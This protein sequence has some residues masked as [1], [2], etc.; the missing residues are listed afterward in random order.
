MLKRIIAQARKEL[1]QVSRPAHGGARPRAAADTA[2][3]VLLYF[4]GALCVLAGIGLGTFLATFSKVAT[5]GSVVEFFVNPPLGMLSG[6]MTPIDAMPDW[7]QPLTL[8]N[9]VRYFATTARGIM[10]KGAGGEVLYPNLLALIGFAVLL[11]GVSAW[12]FRK[13]LG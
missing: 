3:A 2:C 9:P 1:T 13:Q 4:G 11:V 10:L 5:A 7:L 12:R 8:I 6:A